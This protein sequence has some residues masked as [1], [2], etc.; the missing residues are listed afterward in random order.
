[1]LRLPAPEEKVVQGE[2]RVA[3][4][5]LLVTVGIPPDKHADVWHDLEPAMDK[6]D[7]G[8]KDREKGTPV[9]RDGI[10]RARKLVRCPPS[11]YE[12]KPLH[13]RSGLDDER[14]RH[15]SSL[16]GGSALELENSLHPRRWGW[17]GKRVMV[18]RYAVTPGNRTAPDRHGAAL[19]RGKERIA[20]GDVVHHL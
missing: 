13:L 10:G 5:H 19:R 17:R 9:G 15:R 12:A 4:I 7:R 14:N 2:P 20:R 18:I 1:A 11:I 8:L 3:Y 6:N 16:K